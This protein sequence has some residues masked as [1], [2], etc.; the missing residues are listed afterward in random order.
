MPIRPKRISSVRN[1]QVCFREDGY[2]VVIDIYSDDHNPPHMHVS[3]IGNRR[4]QCRYIITDT[5]PQSIRDLRLMKGDRDVF[6]TKIKN[7]VVCW[8]N[9]TESS[10]VLTWKYVKAVWGSDDVFP[11][12]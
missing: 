11:E 7:N 10:G 1:E 12:I 3:L 9:G 4:I 6:S 8:A 5:P 2:G